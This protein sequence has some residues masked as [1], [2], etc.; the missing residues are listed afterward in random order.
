MFFLFCLRRQWNKQT[1]SKRCAFTLFNDKHK[2]GDRKDDAAFLT[3]TSKRA[4][5]EVNVDDEVLYFGQVKHFDKFM[6]NHV[7][8]KEY[9]SYKRERKSFV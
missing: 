2:V 1:D 9:L 8:V 4:K 7:A 3:A 6:R 5:L